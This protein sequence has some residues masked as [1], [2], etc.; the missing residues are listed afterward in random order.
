MTT[1]VD[2]PMSAP[3]E[4]GPDRHAD[5]AMAAR[6][7]ARDPRRPGRRTARAAARATHRSGHRPRRML[8]DPTPWAAAITTMTV[9]LWALTGGLDSLVSGGIDAALAISRLSGLVAALAAL[10]GL[11]LTARPMWL[12]RSTGLD[13]MI[14]WHRITGMTAAFGM[15]VH[16]AA[17]LYAAGGGITGLWTGLTDLVGTDWFVA[18]LVAAAL[19]AAVSLTSWRRIRTWMSYET[20]HMVHLAGYLAVALAFPHA[21]FSGSTLNG[22]TVA[23]WWWVGLYAATTVII[24]ASRVGGIVRS[25]LRPRTSIA[26]I[27]REAPGV[28]SLVITGPGVDRLGAQPGQFVGLRVL[29]RDLWWQSHPYSLSAAPRPGALRLTVK[30]LGDASARTLGLP[31]GTRVLLEGPYGVIRMESAQGRRV[32]LIGVGVGLAPMRALLEEATP[33]HAPL[34]LARAHSAADMPLAREF[35]QMARDRGGAMIPI[36][37]PRTTFPGGNPF[38]AEALTANIGDLRSRAVF[39]CGPQSLQD[40]VCRELERAGVPRDQIHSERFAW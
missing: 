31:P 2:P 5:A 21:L 33:T 38:T 40:R 22:S 6:T 30:A 16:V 39:V 15:V 9:G 20:W 3:P 29:T 34:V 28:G 37:G 35:D 7:A 27:V 25:A 24:L 12:E 1:T 23:G 26:R 17:S 10:G 8:R 11:V 19:F 14:S 4:P 18:A 32:L 36:T 13:R